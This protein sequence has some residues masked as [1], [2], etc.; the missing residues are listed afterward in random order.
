MKWKIQ[1]AALKPEDSEPVNI[2]MSF[3]NPKGTNTAEAVLSVQILGVVLDV[4]ID[5][6]EDEKVAVIITLL[7]TEINWNFLL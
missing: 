2:T 1:G 6:G 7:K 4:I 3:P 5:E